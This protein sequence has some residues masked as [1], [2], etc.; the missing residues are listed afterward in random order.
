M[1]RGLFQI[2]ERVRGRVSWGWDPVPLRVVRVNHRETQ[3]D[4]EN[5]RVPAI[6][7]T[8]SSPG[9]MIQGDGDRNIIVSYCT[10]TPH[11]VPIDNSESSAGCMALRAA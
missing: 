7:T 10:F 5:Q 3:E 11:C 1:Q 8:S 6:H 4:E 2:S 9:T